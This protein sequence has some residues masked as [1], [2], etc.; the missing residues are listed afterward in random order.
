LSEYPAYLCEWAN[1]SG[2]KR[3]LTAQDDDRFGAVCGAL[4]TESRPEAA[5]Q[6]VA[7]IESELMSELSFIP[8]FTLTQAD[9]YRNLAYP[10]PTLL[11]GWTGWYGAPSYAVPAP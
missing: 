10:V 2:E 6:A 5:R 1:D 8:L 9:V 3:L 7:Q 11:N 4:E